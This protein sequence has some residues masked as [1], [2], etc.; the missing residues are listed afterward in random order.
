MP[1][2]D[3]SHSIETGIQTYPG[4]PSVSLSPHA[5]FDDDG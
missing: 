2:F 3:L 4:D 5:S 1:T